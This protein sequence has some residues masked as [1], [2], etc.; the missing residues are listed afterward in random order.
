VESTRARCHTISV[1]S[2]GLFLTVSDES[3]KLTSLHKLT[4]HLTVIHSSISPFHLCET[5]VFVP[6]RHRM[7]QSAPG[8]K[9]KG[10]DPSK[11]CSAED[12]AKWFEEQ[13]DR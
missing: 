8:D 4:S 7:F 13:I 10:V 5:L 2:I 11:V 9:R 6:A 1:S 12:V 3:Q